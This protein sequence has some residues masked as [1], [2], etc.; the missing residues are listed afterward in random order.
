MAIDSAC[1]GSSSHCTAAKPALAP[2]YGAPRLAAKLLTSSSTPRANDSAANASAPPQTRIA[3]C[4]IT[5][6][7]RSSRTSTSGRSAALAVS[8]SERVQ[9]CSLSAMAAFSWPFLIISISCRSKPLI[10]SRS[11]SI[12]RSC[13]DTARWPCGLASCTEASS[14]A[15]RS[16]KPGLVAR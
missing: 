4:G 3:A 16:K 2:Q 5:N 15:W 1:A 12:C 9:R 8:I 11:I 7:W 6:S 13:S 14:S 10:L